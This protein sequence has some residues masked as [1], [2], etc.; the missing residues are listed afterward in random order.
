MAPV[1][2]KKTLIN[3]YWLMKT[4]TCE[5]RFWDAGWMASVALVLG[6]MLI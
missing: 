6:C 1:A 3:Y 2:M 4:T 5:D